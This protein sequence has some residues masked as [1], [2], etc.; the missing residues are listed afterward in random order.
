MNIERQEFQTHF[1]LNSSLVI[2]QSERNSLLIVSC[3]I[4]TEFYVAVHKANI[5]H[6][7][8][9]RHFKL[10]LLD[11]I[12]MLEENQYFYHLDK[13]S[14]ITFILSVHPEKE[15]KNIYPNPISLFHIGLAPPK[16][17]IY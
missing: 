6:I 5:V 4:T 17:M 15:T 8:D 2:I 13:I 11:P 1:K 16:K 14:Y 12:I 9:I 3:I 7:H 10:L